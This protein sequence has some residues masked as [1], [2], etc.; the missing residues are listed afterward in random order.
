MKYELN[1]IF[2]CNENPDL[3]RAYWK[4][5]L[6]TTKRWNGKAIS[7]F[8]HDRIAAQAQLCC[9]EHTG[10][11]LREVSFFSE[12]DFQSFS[13]P[14]ISIFVFCLLDHCHSCF[15]LLLG[16]LYLFASFCYRSGSVIHKHADPQISNSTLCTTP[17]KPCVFSLAHFCSSL[18]Q[19]L[20]K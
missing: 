6:K 14:H 5:Q 7:V 8:T 12:P 3:L 17:D 19:Y 1:S 15:L 13:R 20:R 10:S 18:S 4:V 2:D 16:S 9:P 11:T